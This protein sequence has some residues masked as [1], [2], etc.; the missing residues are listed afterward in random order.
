M[1]KQRHL[2]HVG[3]PG[4]VFEKLFRKAAIPCDPDT[5]IPDVVGGTLFWHRERLEPPVH[6]PGSEGDGTE[7]VASARLNR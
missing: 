3:K 7:E 5:Q 1:P 6:I 2:L 4:G